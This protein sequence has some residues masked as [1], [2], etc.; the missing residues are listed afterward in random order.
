MYIRFP[1]QL[2]A[3]RSP[4]SQCSFEEDKEDGSGSEESG[5]SKKKKK[6][7]ICICSPVNKKVC[8]SDGETYTNRCFAKCKKVKVECKRVGISKFMLQQ[9]LLASNFILH[10]RGARVQSCQRKRTSPKRMT[11]TTTIMM[12]T[13]PKRRK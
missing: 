7:S 12:R 5:D 2:I 13:S 11:T 10:L 6:A 3:C 4:C 8:G 9:Q 1:F